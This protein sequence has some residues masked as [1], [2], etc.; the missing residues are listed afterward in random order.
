[1]NSHDDAGGEDDPYQ[2]DDK[3]YQE[4]FRK[5]FITE[6][7]KKMM[8]GDPTADSKQNWTLHDMIIPAGKTAKLIRI[9]DP[10]DPDFR[11]SEI[12]DK[13]KFVNPCPVIMLAG[14]MSQRAG[15]ALAGACRAAFRTDA[16]IIDSGVGSGIEKFCLRKSNFFVSILLHKL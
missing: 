11:V 14:A 5:T 6:N 1:L 10:K 9:K 2:G 4:H 7:Q 16:F 12:C 15:K 13:I 8:G 3:T